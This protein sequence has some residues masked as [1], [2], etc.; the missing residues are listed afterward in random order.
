MTS[1][2]SAVL[3]AVGILAVGLAQA[4]TNATAPDGTPVECPNFSVRLRGPS[5][6]GG[7]LSCGR[8]VIG[9][10][11]GES[12]LTIKGR[13]SAA[14]DGEDA[15]KALIGSWH[16][17]GAILTLSA[18]GTFEKISH[19]SPGSYGGA[20]DD[21]GE[22]EIRGDTIVFRGFLVKKS[23][24]FSFG[25]DS[26]LVYQL[27]DLPLDQPVLLLTSERQ[28]TS[29][30]IRRGTVRLDFV[31]G[32]KPISEGPSYRLLPRRQSSGGSG[33]SIC[34]VAYNRD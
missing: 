19:I 26:S 13:Q 32:T 23:C 5:F 18:D 22:Y 7:S 16:T 11:P 21:R 20:F 12:E 6:S 25:S 29:V 27:G 3:A 31:V 10:G 33:L 15:K 17:Q 24:N 2:F 30:V 14:S 8:F 34:D 4:Q 28:P 1:N 9:V